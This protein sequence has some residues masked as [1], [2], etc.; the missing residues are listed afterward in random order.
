LSPI[1]G[2]FLASRNLSIYF[3]LR[4]GLQEARPVASQGRRSY[5]AKF[6]NLPFA[7]MPLMPGSPY[8]TEP[9]S[10]QA[11][12][13][14][15]FIESPDRTL[16][17]TA[18]MLRPNMIL[19]ESCTHSSAAVVPAAMAISRFRPDLPDDLPARQARAS[20]RMSGMSNWIC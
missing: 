20:M 1:A 2:K 16:L 18:M 13:R 11:W 6:S 3:V 14:S 9:R 4:S 5:G 15:P 19:A 8:G 7:A 17:A 12:D 10:E